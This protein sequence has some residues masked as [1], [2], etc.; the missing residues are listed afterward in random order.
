MA[1]RPHY[2]VYVV[3]LAK[4][5]LDEPRFRKANRD[6]EAGKPCVYVGMT[7]LSPDVRFDKHKAGIQANRFVQQYGLRL[8]P[9]LYEPYNPM[10]YDEAR[11]MEVEVAIDL[12]EGGYGVWQA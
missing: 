1:R 4:A 12:R 8:L 2:S 7:G 10:R 5:V 9:P 3:E 6:Y 11:D